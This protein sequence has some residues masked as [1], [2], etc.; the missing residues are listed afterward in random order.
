[1]TSGSVLGTLFRFE[2]KML[3]RDRRTILVSIVLPILVMP[4]LLFSSSMTER[5]REERQEAKVFRYAVV[6]AEAELARQVIASYEPVASEAESEDPDL[7]LEEVDSTDP[8]GELEAQTL[9]FFVEASP[10][11]VWLAEQ[12]EE[13]KDD[14]PVA[15]T[16]RA[17]EE[18]PLP[19][20][21]LVYRANWDDSETASGEMQARLVSAR[22]NLRQKALEERGFPVAASEVAV[23]EDNDLATA[24]Q[25]TGATVGRFATVFV[26]LFLLTGGSVVAAD[27]I[28]GEKERG[29]LETVLTTAA[30]RRDIVGA[31][32]LLILAVGVGITVIQI[33]NLLLYV[34]LNLIEVPE[35]FAVDLSAGTVVLL[36]L[37]FL[38]LA[39][40]AGSVL[41]WV[42]GY[43]KTYK[44]FQ[45]YF[46][47]VFLLL[48]APALASMLP[49]VELRSAVVL[50]PIANLSVA[51]RSVLVGGFD[52]LF[53]AIAWLVSMAAA[54]FAG[55]STLRALSTERLIT[56]SELDRADLEGGAA[57]FPRHAWRWFLGMWV[58]ML[59]VATNIESMQSL[60]PQV[61]FNLLG[62]FLGGSMLMIWRYR[63]PVREVLALRPVKPVIWLA[64]LLGAPAFHLA[65]ITVAKVSSH[66]FPIP[67]RMLEGFGEFLMPAE[68]PA[69][70]IFLL[71]AVLPGICEEITFRGVLLHAL[72]QRL[73]PVALCLV[74]GVIFGLFHI[75]L[76][77]LLP[78]A[79]LGTA[80]AALTLVTGS[81]FPAMLWH[82]LNNACAIAS[83]YVGLP[84]T[85][86]ESWAYAAAWLVFGLVCFLLWRHRSVYPGLRRQRGQVLRLNH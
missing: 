11:G 63:L 40:I 48:L 13:T 60:R 44:E 39:A 56:A 82:A 67:K 2:L 16:E 15:V 62:I 9:H 66:L 49:A 47:P 43:A 21:R 77:R 19:L 72:R 68:I 57:V 59:L 12:A 64:V 86:L 75:D 83:G 36:L 54:V 17:A 33:L 35:S 45:L 29:T 73:R 70:E 30:S 7:Q 5:S 55:W 18:I 27:T 51:V 78:T 37:L 8:E 61:L 80:M 85:E 76:I 42:S 79:L 65:L 74:V 10:P 53:L 25:R 46:F 38:P 23:V 52:P 28:A 41:L 1:M 34:G 4:L 81:I 24:S 26:L 14:A 22:V 3:L 31:K 20:L 71:V 84:L 6:G 58:I 69:W 32:L 50:V